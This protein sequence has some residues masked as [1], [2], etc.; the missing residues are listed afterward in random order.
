M[1]ED[2]ELAELETELI[3][4]SIEYR[5]ELLHGALT[6]GQ[7]AA[8]L[9]L[10][11][12]DVMKRLEARDILGIFDQ[13]EWRFPVAQFEQ[14]K[15]LPGLPDVIKILSENKVTPLEQLSWLIEPHPTFGTSPMEVLRAGETSRIIAGAR[16][17]NVS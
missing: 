14:G 8:L 4:A 5:K 17:V 13:G 10:S 11:A 2:R 9:Q 15:I 3:K 1:N 6:V 12:A 16:A 7:A